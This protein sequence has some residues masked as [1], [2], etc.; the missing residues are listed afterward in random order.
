MPP[1]RTSV[2]GSARDTFDIPASVEANVLVDGGPTGASVSSPGPIVW[3]THSGGVLSGW[4]LVTNG[5][6][7]SVP[8]GGQ[9]FFTSVS[10]ETIRLTITRP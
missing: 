10:N 2:A 3:A 7:V 4:T 1:I 9:R 5:A 8:A 6:T